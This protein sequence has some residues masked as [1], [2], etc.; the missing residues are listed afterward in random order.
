MFKDYIIPALNFLGEKPVFVEGQIDEALTVEKVLSTPSITSALSAENFNKENY[1]PNPNVIRSSYEKIKA[2]RNSKEGTEALRAQLAF[3]T[4]YYVVKQQNQILL[5]L[6]SNIDFNTANYRINTEFYATSTG[7]N[8]AREN[9]NSEAIDKILT[10]SVVSPFNVLE[11][12]QSVVDQVWDFFSLPLVKDYLYKVKQEYGKYWSRDKTVRNFNQLM[13]SMMLSFFQNIPELKPLYAKYGAE[14]GLLDIKSGNNL[15]ARFDR[16]FNNTEDPKI[17]AFASNNIILN[18][19]TSIMVE[20]TS[21]FY[22]GMLTNEK[23][24]DTVNAGTKRLL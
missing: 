22:P 8:E 24:V 11:A 6:T 13:N 21:M 23:D 4:Q 3:I 16:I 18:N 20:G 10:N 15:R 2:N 19:F 5:S 14:S 9:F 7:I 17:K 1:P 12:N